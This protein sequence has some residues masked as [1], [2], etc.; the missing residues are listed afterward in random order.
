MRC[1]ETWP[2]VAR[3]RLS[4]IATILLTLWFCQ[5]LLINDSVP[6]FRDLSTYFYPLRF[7]LFDSFRSGQLPLWNRHMAMGFPVLADFQ[8]A[9]FYPPH[10]LFF[11]MPFFT[12]VRFIFVL[13]FLI[14]AAGAYQLLRHW[15]HPRYLAIL[16]ALLF[17]LGGT[18]VSLTNL[19]NHFQTAVW[20]PWVILAW[21]NAVRSVSWKTFILFVLSL[22]LQLLAGS[23]EVFALSMILVIADGL[24]LREGDPQVSID[25]V[26]PIFVVAAVSTVALTMVQILPTAEL[27]LE[28][29]RNQPIPATEALRWSLPPR[30][31]LNLFFLDKEVDLTTSLGIRLFFA[32]EP[33]FLVS[34]YLGA[35]S[36]V[37]ICLWLCSGSL[38]AKCGLLLLIGLSLMMA[39]GQYTP[40]YPLIL[41]Y[42]P[43]L[44]SVRFPEKVFYLT[45]CLLIY[46]AVKGIAAFMEQDEPRSRKA[47]V[48]IGLMSVVWIS[49][50]LYVRWDPTFVLRLL[51]GNAEVNPASSQMVKTLAGIVSNLERQVILFLAFSSMF[52]LVKYHK[53][54][55]S[56]FTCLV[57][58]TTFVDL[59]WAH[60]DFLFAIKPDFVFSKSRILVKSNHEVHRIFYYPVRQNLHP[61]FWAIPGQPEFK[62]VAALFSYNLMPNH[63]LFQGFDYFQ[64]IDALARRPYTEFLGVANQLHPAAQIKLL[65]TFNVGH[66]MSFWPLEVDGLSLI[67]RVP[68]YY[69]WLYKIDRPV[70]RLYFVNKSSHENDPEKILR[71]LASREFNPAQEV[72]L[73]RDPGI[74]SNGELVAT[75]EIVRYDHQSVTI[76]AALNNSG[77]LVL[78]DSFYPGWKAYV[79]GKETAI[80]KANHFFRALSLSQGQH[81]IEFKYEPLSFRIGLIVSLM[82]ALCIVLASVF[83]FL[84]NR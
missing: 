37:G 71:R 27:F 76:R 79:D 1:N 84:R 75:G 44:G 19:L 31:L 77:V 82:T 8:S 59:T 4:L 81:M 18:I 42:Y 38:R 70:P 57:V 66:V 46:V 50:Y 54:R 23:P 73:N 51:L 60:R 34:Y 16:G 53:I 2:N 28:S 72:I 24:R 65:R 15:S 39:L 69:S 21:E 9:A 26:I 35:V 49:A 30:N 80:L 45:F 20:L 68:Q 33:S 36:L 48:A 83:L 14:A 32:K 55:H 78:A 6:F 62:D 25:R 58:S 29:R 43:M 10:L 11:F 47:I 13:H 41:Q 64:E 67:D 74:T 61:S 7:T 56:L 22:C 3:E 52:V 17:T 40:V 5:D 12:A 63:G